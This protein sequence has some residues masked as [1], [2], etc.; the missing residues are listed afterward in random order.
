MSYG[1]ACTIGWGVE[2]FG[3]IPRPECRHGMWWLL[4]EQHSRR[5]LEE[6]SDATYTRWLE[7]S[8]YGGHEF[9]GFHCPAG[10]ASRLQRRFRQRDRRRILVV[11]LRLV[12]V[13]CLE[14]RPVLQQQQHQPLQQRPYQRRLGSLLQGLG[15]WVGGFDHL[16]IAPDRKGGW[17]VSLRSCIKEVSQ[18]SN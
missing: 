17:L 8:E 15:Q 3:E 7:Y 13:R 18:R 16:T 5:S 4:A 1:L 14:P 12:C 9:I 11:L 10:R 6:H 2:P